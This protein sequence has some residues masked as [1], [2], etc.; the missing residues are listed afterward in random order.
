MLYP[1]T[2]LQHA[3]VLS[4]QKMVKSM[5]FS[6]CLFLCFAVARNSFHPFVCA[7]MWLEKLSWFF[8]WLQVHQVMALKGGY[9][10]ALVEQRSWFDAY[11]P[12]QP[13]RI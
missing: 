8:V 2:R 9:G 11:M 13:G 5:I 12:F 6:L 10:K 4:L 7:I 3:S 1:S